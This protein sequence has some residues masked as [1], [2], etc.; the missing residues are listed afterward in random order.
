MDRNPAFTAQLVLEQKYQASF[1]KILMDSSFSTFITR[2]VSRVLYAI[3]AWLTVAAGVILELM[4]IYS[5][6]VNGA[7]SY[8]AAYSIIAIFVI[9]IATFLLL[10]SLRL[11]F[12][13]G[14]ALVLIAENTM[15]KK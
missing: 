10:I 9:P 2:R 15:P 11:I 4:S 14:I 12:E 8:F 5:A 7:S 1:F 6:I 13:T 3:T